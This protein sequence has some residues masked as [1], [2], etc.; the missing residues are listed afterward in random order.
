MKMENKEGIKKWLIFALILI[1]GFTIAGIEFSWYFL[2]CLLFL[3][4]IFKREQYIRMTLSKNKRECEELMG[5]LSE[6]RHWYY[7]YN[8]VEDA[9]LEALETTRGYSI[10]SQLKLVYSKLTSEK[11]Q[12]EGYGE[13]R[14][15]Y[16]IYT[17]CRITKEYGDS[18][19]QEKSQFIQNL[20]LLREE[21]HTVRRHL[22]LQQTAFIGI[23]PIAVIPIF[24]LPMIKSWGCDNL[25][26]LHVLYEGT[27]GILITFFLCLFS[28]IIYEILC[29]FRYIDGVLI[30]KYILIEWLLTKEWVH[31]KLEHYKKKHELTLEKIKEQLQ[32]AGELISLNQLLLLQLFYKI[33]AGTI[34]FILWLL[35]GR[36]GSIFAWIFLGYLSILISAKI[37][38]FQI[39]FQIRFYKKYREKEA[40]EFQGIVSMMMRLSRIS[41][42]ELL[43]TMEE[44]SICYKAILRRC[45]L[46]LPYDEQAA[47]IQAKEEVNGCKGMER[48]IEN[49]M[50]CDKIGPILALEEAAK[51]RK[52]YK[53]L[54]EEEEKQKLSDQASIAQ[55]IAFCPFFAVV[56]LFLIVPF[57]YESLNELMGVSGT[58]GSW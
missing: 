18:F 57:I 30:K 25:P 52:F 40:S 21:M 15:L 31:K 13:N 1:V 20:S 37:P 6:L 8:M 50:M 56:L 26:E 44:T 27:Y 43:E 22:K 42:Y 12:K 53:E 45:L 28:I 17:L 32:E 36:K 33:A 51:E 48:L 23:I 41:I 14:Y 5:F 3:R 58:L 11:E 9:F 55:L 10:N 7:V 34:V 4:H 19:H 47:L 46:A 38:M 39:W 49:L 29:L 2:F 16:L 35:V 24:T 54:H